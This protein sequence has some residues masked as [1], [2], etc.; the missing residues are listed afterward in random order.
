MFIRHG[1]IRE[2]DVVYGMGDTSEPD[3]WMADEMGEAVARRE[4]GGGQWA[5]E[6]RGFVPT[7]IVLAGPGGVEERVFVFAEE[8]LVDGDGVYGMYDVTWE[9]SGDRLPAG[10]WRVVSVFVRDAD[11]MEVVFEGA[12]LSAS[13][14]MVQLYVLGSRIDIAP[15]QLLRL[16]LPP[17]RRVVTYASPSRSH[18]Y[19]SRALL[20]LLVEIVDDLSGLQ[21]DFVRG[22]G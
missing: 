13:G 8:H 22:E 10:E 14:Y 15:P 19:T 18:G 2:E 4:G 9:F 6:G 7:Q 3:W 17:D 1:V 12:D 11:D 20:T 21:Q 16:A 5:E